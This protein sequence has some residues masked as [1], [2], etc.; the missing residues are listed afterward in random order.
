M[1]EFSYIARDNAGQK[2]TG[3]VSADGRREALA[4]LAARALFPIDVTT[5]E[6]VVENRR[7][8]R[9][10]AQL[11]ATTYGQLADLL[12]SGVPLLRSVSVLREQTSHA[13][14]KHILGQVHK[15]VEDGSTLAEAMG[16][17]QNIFGGMAVSMVRAGSEGGFLE[18]ALLRVAQFTETQEDLKKR[19]LGAIIYPAIL[20]VVIVTVVTILV[21][22]FVP[23]F[24]DLFDNLRER[25]ELPWLTDWLLWT[26]KHVGGN[27]VWIVLAIGGGGYAA[28]RWLRTEAGRLWWDRMRLK[29]PMA[30][31]IY[32]S[33]AVSRFCRVLGTML[34]NGVPIIRSLEISSDATGNRVLSAAIQEATENISAGQSLAEPLGESGQFPAMVV[35]MIAVAEQANNLENVLIS[36][37]DGLDRRTWRR[38]DLAVRMLEPMLLVVLATVVMAVVIALLLPLL[39]MAGSV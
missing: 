5:D 18:E 27:F 34:R 17:F 39:R 9:V 10:P 26:S 4:L 23:M 24:D 19:T 12:V 20:T 30:G 36:V 15:H 16:Q 11:M 28:W 7:V 13:G 33:L 32:R 37:A 14:L 3:T 31:G 25:G 2:V 1:P 6:P 22:F 38:L 21:V 35:E 29:V 8:R